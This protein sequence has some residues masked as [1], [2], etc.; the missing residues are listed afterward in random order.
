[1]RRPA[2]RRLLTVAAVFV[3]LLAAPLRA[4]TDEG[5]VDTPWQCPSGPALCLED[6][7]DGAG[8]TALPRHA[9]E[10]GA[11]ALLALGAVGLV[12]ARLHGRKDDDGSRGSA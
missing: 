7:H 4:C 11:L 3:L 1:M 6:G 8:D 10:P 5:L 2:M 12:V 9:P